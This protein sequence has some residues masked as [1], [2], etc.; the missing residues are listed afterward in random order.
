MA[1]AT[2]VTIETT[3]NGTVEKAW[4]YYTG[5]Q[6]ITQWNSPSEDWHSP[7]A[8]NDLRAGGAFNYRM[9]ARD[10]SFGFDFA[11]IYDAVRPQDHIAYTL[12]DGRKALI[13]FKPE[14][15]QVRVTIQFDPEN[16]NPVEMQRAGWQA[17]L[18]NFRKYTESH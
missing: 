4:D 1:A 14:G 7:S 11:G 8:S 18:D 17:I 3:V 5:E 16:E 2:K 9:E 13:D 10:G 15:D 12:G 6:H